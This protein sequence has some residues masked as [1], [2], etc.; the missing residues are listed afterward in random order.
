[1]RVASRFA[2]EIRKSCFPRTRTG[3]HCSAQDTQ[4]R[5]MPPRSVQNPS[6]PV[7]DPTHKTPGQ[8]TPGLAMH[9]PD[10]AVESDRLSGQARR[11]LV[12]AR[13]VG[14]GVRAGTHRG[15]PGG[16]VEGREWAR[17]GVEDCAACR[18]RM[19]VKKATAWVAWL[20]TV[21]ACTTL[22]PSRKGRGLGRPVTGAEQKPRP[23]LVRGFFVCAAH[24]TLYG[25][26][27]GDTRKG[28]PV[29]SRSSNPARSAAFHLDVGGGRFS[30]L[31]TGAFYG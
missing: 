22:R 25:G 28:V 16:A 31:L 21:R 3:I 24:C 20:P 8:G 12:C 23:L 9:R 26:P 19:G 15:R 29:L 4:V 17:Q 1:M 27:C 2:G 5:A 18:P 7:T 11:G 6:K 10:T 14:L 30:N 13:R